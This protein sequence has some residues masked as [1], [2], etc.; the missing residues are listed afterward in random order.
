METT[1]K[2]AHTTAGPIPMSTLTNGT[3]SAISNEIGLTTFGFPKGMKVECLHVKDIFLDMINDLENSLRHLGS[4]EYERGSNLD[5][6]EDG[7]LR[8]LTNIKRA[9]TITT[10]DGD[11]GLFDQFIDDYADDMNGS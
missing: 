5:V 9:V 3:S 6:E 7:L 8:A 1:V 10:Y 11:F 4:L 2:Y